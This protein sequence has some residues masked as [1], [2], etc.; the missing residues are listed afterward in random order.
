MPSRSQSLKTILDSL[1]KVGV[2]PAAAAWFEAHL[3]EISAELRDTV[4]DEIPAFLESR[5]P[6]IAPEQQAHADEHVQ[7]ILRFL[8]GATD[9]D[10][11]F[12]RGHAAR[13][14]EQRF[15]LEATLHAYRTGHR[16]LSKWIRE[17]ALANADEAASVGETLAAVADFAIEYTDSISTIAT[18]EYVAQTRLL[19]EV[20]GDRRSR[21]LGVLLGGYDEADGRVAVLLRRAGYLDQRQSFCVAVAQSVDPTEMENPARVRR[22]IDAI[23]DVLESFASRALIGIHGDKVVVVFSATRRISGWTAVQTTLA[24]QVQPYLLRLGNAVLVGVS[25]DKPSTSHIPKA[26][27]EA[28]VALE[29]ADASNRVVGFSG[30][31]VRRVLLRQAQDSVR[32]ALPKWSSAFFAADDKARGSLVATLRAYADADM[33]VLKAARSL[34]VHPNTIYSRMLRIADITDQDG[35]GYHAL[36]ELLLTAD[37]RP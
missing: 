21:L 15:P 34:K 37:C 28:N 36:T 24:E 6:D 19:A 23:E 30:I 25:T 10:F 26:L 5:N 17:A 1:A 7:Q 2:I 8:G 35:L 3:D 22:I 12:V 4:R 20:E 31:P 33:N 16:V 11:D 29:F 27:S 14:A 32:P 13:R 9:G 18:S